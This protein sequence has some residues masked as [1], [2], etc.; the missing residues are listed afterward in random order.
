MAVLVGLDKVSRAS[1]IEI[2]NSYVSK[3]HEPIVS[4]RGGASVGNILKCLV[5]P[6][7][8]ELKAFE[9]TMDGALELLSAGGILLRRRWP[10]STEV[11]AACLRGFQGRQG[12][13]C[14][15]FNASVGR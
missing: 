1:G 3:E 15:H 2:Q 9:E 6:V 11:H 7:G 12:S 14:L 4:I 5:P 13:C 8:L 10:L